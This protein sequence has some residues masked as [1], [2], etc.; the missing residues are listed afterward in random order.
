MYIG[1]NNDITFSS[2]SSSSYYLS[3]SSLN[4][5][6]TNNFAIIQLGNYY[7]DSTLTSQY[8]NIFTSSI[9]NIYILNLNLTK[10]YTLRVYE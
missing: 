7:F 9:S 10:E 6:S 4:T 3:N 8:N 2:I 1:D 5:I